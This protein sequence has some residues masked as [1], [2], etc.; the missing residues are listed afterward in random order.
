MNFDRVFSVARNSGTSHIRFCTK[1]GLAHHC[2]PGRAAI[3]FGSDYAGMA[4]LRGTAISQ[5]GHH[6]LPDGLLTRV[7]GGVDDGADFAKI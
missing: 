6:R 3:G 2:G 1:R 7:A 5:I 4:L